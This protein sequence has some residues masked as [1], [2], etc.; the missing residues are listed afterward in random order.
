MITTEVGP[1]WGDRNPPR[2]V[3]VLRDAGQRM[4][5]GRTK[6]RGTPRKVMCDIERSVVPCDTLLKGGIGTLVMYPL[7]HY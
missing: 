2:R 1:G 3:K 6:R 4:V 7:T 5:G